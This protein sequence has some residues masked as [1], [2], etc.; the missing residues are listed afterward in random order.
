MVRA[1]EPLACSRGLLQPGDDRADLEP[2]VLCAASV[3]AF[4]ADSPQESEQNDF[5]EDWFFP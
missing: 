1:A 5:S 4:A 2:M 3:R